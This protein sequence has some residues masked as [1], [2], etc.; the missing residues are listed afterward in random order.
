MFKSRNSILHNIP[1]TSAYW[2]FVGVIIN[3]IYL[4][5]LFILFIKGIFVIFFFCEKRFS[6][7]KDMAVLME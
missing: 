3:A 6:L 2:N 1:I 7:L 5:Y 4:R